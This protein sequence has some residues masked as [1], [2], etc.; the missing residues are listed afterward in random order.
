MLKA[1]HFFFFILALIAP[2][3]GFSQ[4]SGF[5]N[6]TL[7]EFARRKGLTEPG[8]YGLGIFHR[9]MDKSPDELFLGKDSA[10]KENNLWNYEFLPIYTSLLSD[11]KRPYGSGEFGIIPA[12]GSQFFF[13]TGV[14]A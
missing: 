4:E 1:F 10:S 12:R 11:G 7:D 5:G 3:F 9:S 6:L 2:L 8:K 14:K 13:S